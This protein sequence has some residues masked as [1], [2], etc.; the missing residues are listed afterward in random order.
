MPLDGTCGSDTVAS[1]TRHMCSTGRQQMGRVWQPCQSATECTEYVMLVCESHE[2]ETCRRGALLLGLNNVDCK[3]HACEHV[4]SSH[5]PMQPR[6]T[7][8]SVGCR[9]SGVSM[10]NVQIRHAFRDQ[11]N[12]DLADSCDMRNGILATCVPHTVQS[13]DRTSRSVARAPNYS[14]L[15]G[16]LTLGDAH[17]AL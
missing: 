11:V 12:V 6:L 17:Y 7:F 2:L 8:G 1:S 10:C 14:N 16:S 4:T 9:K 5:A 13:V 3:A 15:A